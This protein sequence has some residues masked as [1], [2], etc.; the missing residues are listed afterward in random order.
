MS[1]NFVIKKPLLNQE[2]DWVVQQV[3]SSAYSYQLSSFKAR[4]PQ[5]SKVVMRLTLKGLFVGGKKFNDQSR[6]AT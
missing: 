2:I 1:D 5:D 6:I 4:P 3:K